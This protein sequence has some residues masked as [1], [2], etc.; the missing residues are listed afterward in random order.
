MNISYISSW[1]AVKPTA[2]HFADVNYFMFTDCL[3]Y[4]DSTQTGPNQLKL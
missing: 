4:I 1:Y 2:N 3:V